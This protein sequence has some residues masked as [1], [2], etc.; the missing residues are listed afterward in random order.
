LTG[1][2][3]FERGIMKEVIATIFA[4]LLAVSV[5][6]AA[7]PTDSFA[8]LVVKNVSTVATAGAASTNESKI[9]GY[10]D[11]VY[12]QLADGGT[13]LGTN[14]VTTDPDITGSYFLGGT[15]GGSNYYVRDDG[16]VSH[17]Y[18]N[19]QW[20]VAPTLGAVTGKAYTNLTMSE[21]GLFAAVGA[22][23]TGTLSMV[24]YVYDIDVD[25]EVIANGN[26]MGVARPILSMDNISGSVLYHPREIADTTG[27]VE[28][29]AE[30]VKI[31]LCIDKIRLHAYDASSTGVTVRAYFILQK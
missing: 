27:G 12:V 20:Y 18:T 23:A 1:A 11:A 22:T 4:S 2:P 5:S 6:M 26:N 28:I 16:A 15:Y 19:G 14:S 3:P 10:V 25:I 29:S 30:P 31:P 9:S 21:T 8:S 24:D 17:Y 13:Y 7:S